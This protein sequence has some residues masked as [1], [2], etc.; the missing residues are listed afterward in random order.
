M[1]SYALNDHPARRDN[2]HCIA[3][4]S[5][6]KAEW[7]D[8]K[9]ICA[10]HAPVQII[11]VEQVP[12]IPVLEIEVLCQDAQT[13]STLDDAWMTYTETSPHRPHSME[14]ARVW[15]ER[16]NPSPYIAHDW[17]F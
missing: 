2:P 8:L 12:T 17:R 5:V 13:A 1:R 15:G 3:R 6:Y 10:K 14:E 16:H 9:A 7:D 4:L 11:G